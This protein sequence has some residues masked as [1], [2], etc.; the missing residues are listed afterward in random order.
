[1]HGCDSWSH[2]YIYIDIWEHRNN[3]A[4]EI[5]LSSDRR[6]KEDDENYIISGFMTYTFSGVSRNF[7]REGGSQQIQLRAEDREN[8]NLG[9][10]T[11]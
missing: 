6:I 4:K 1:M 8:R 10:L 7:I 5:I 2:I 11:P 3:T 9:A